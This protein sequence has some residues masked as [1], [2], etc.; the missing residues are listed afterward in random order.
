[1]KTNKKQCIICWKE[2][3]QSLRCLDCY[4]NTYND[5]KVTNYLL[6]KK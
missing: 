5:K 4:C 2:I 6:N 1:M 3:L